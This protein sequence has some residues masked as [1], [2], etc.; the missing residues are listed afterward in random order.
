MLKKILIVDDN[1]DN[2]LTLELLLEEM[3]DVELSSAS[4][5]LEAL[6]L[7]KNSFYDI[8]F[9]DVM[10]P[11]MDGITSTKEIKKIS[12]KSMI[13]AVSALDNEEQKKEM[14]LSGA[15]DYIRKPIDSSVFVK[16]TQ[17]YI[18]LLDLREK[19]VFDHLA[20]NLFT[21][22]LFNRITTFRVSNKILGIFYVR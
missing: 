5:G 18:E 22:E 8:I 9:M 4:D 17:N 13:I 1:K 11:V 10:M 7:C 16:R 21:K 2:R 14:I 20:S 12:P 3:E 19:R 15:E 6:E